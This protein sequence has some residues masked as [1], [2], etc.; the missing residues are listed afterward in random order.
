MLEFGIKRGIEVRYLELMPHDRRVCQGLKLS[1]PTSNFRTGRLS[2]HREQPW[3]CRLNE[4]VVL[5]RK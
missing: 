5:I 3:F 4:K 2:F 1:H